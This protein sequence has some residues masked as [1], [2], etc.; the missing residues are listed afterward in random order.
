LCYDDTNYKAT[1]GEGCFGK[2]I[3]GHKESIIKPSIEARIEIASKVN[4]KEG[5]GTHNS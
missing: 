3:G 5:I 1:K 4:G 2:T